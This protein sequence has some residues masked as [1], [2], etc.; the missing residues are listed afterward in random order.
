MR[1]QRGFTFIEVLLVVMLVLILMAM[2]FPKM[3]GTFRRGEIESSARELVGVLRYAR[4]LAVLRHGGTQ[5]TINPEA[6]KYQLTLVDLDPDGLPI[7]GQE[8]LLPDESDFRVPDDVRGVKALADSVFFTLIDSTAPTMSPGNLPR[9]I[10][11]PDG[12]ATAAQISIQNENNKAFAVTIY[13]TTGLARVEA[14]QPVLREGAKPL[15][16]LPEKLDYKPA[17]EDGSL[18]DRI[19]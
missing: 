4:H 17:L 13:R 12:S 18:S 7:D 5:V 19:R 11:Y 9:V 15:F 2:A 1:S 6:G 10:F 8:V 14:G 3:G 16:Y